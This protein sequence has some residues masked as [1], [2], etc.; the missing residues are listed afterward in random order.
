MRK[1]NLNKNSGLRILEDSDDDEIEDKFIEQMMNDSDS[2]VDL[3]F[4]SNEKKMF[5][6]KI[7]S[8]SNNS[9]SE[10]CKNDY[11]EFVKLKEE[12]KNL[13][14]KCLLLDNV[15]S[16]Q[17]NEILEKIEKINN[18]IN[19]MI[20]NVKY[21]EVEEVGYLKFEELNKLEKKLLKLFVHIT[22]RISKVYCY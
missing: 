14:N 22:N 2:N 19:S 15:K 18:E 11:M 13:E 6:I 1:C 4:T 16:E 8:H 3:D 20:E 7:K 9:C 17:I 10:N 5:N 12:C 21:Y